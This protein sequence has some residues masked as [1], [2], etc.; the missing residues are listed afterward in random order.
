VVLGFATVAGIGQVSTGATNAAAAADSGAEKVPHLEVI[1]VK[2]NKAGSNGSS[3]GPTPDGVMGKNITVHL[4]LLNAYHLNENQI[5]GEPK[6]SDEEHFDVSGKV[7]D[8]NAA[9]VPKLPMEQKRQAFFQQVL[10]ERFGLIAHNE[11]RALPEYVLVPAKGGAKIEDGKPDPNATP[12]MKNFSGFSTGGNGS[13][14]I[15]RFGDSQIDPLLI[16]LS[17]ETG[18]TVVDKTG[19]TGKY[20]FT[21]KF[22]SDMAKAAADDSTPDLFTAIQEQL[23]LKLEPTKGPVDVLVIDKLERPA[24]N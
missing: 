10:K 15:F 11:T 24:E 1:S 17:N 5:I 3:W 20:S 21:L 22:K 12:E 19:L 6:W 14:M 13:S 4:M 8:A 9:R 16:M 2:P 7:A 18:R 23:G